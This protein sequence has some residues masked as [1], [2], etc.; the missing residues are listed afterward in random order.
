ISRL[1]G[2]CRLLVRTKKTPPSFST[3]LAS[4]T[5]FC[6]SGT[7]SNR[8]SEK[9]ISNELSGKGSRVASATRKSISSPS[10]AARSD[11]FFKSPEFQSIPTGF[12][13]SRAQARLSYPIPQAMS[14]TRFAVLN[15]A[16]DA[17]HLFGLRFKSSC[18]RRRTLRSTYSSAVDN[19]FSQ[20][21][22]VNLYSARNLWNSVP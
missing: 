3:R 8:F 21:F 14:N 12:L 5:I 15:C 7:C 11:A 9:Q 1:T 10:C 20:G 2:Q 13:P 19:G 6:H 22:L 16:S 18:L 17:S 4:E